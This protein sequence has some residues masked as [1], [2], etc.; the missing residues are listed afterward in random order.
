[1]TAERLT[2]RMKMIIDREL[3]PITRN[4]FNLPSDSCAPALKIH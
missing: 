4:F 2:A 1:M 3:G